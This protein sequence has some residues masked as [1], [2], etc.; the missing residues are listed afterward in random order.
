MPGS[1]LMKR[2]PVAMIRASFCTSPASVSTVRPPSLRPVTR[3]AMNST[4]WSLRK[5]SR[6]R[7]RSWPLRNPLGIQIR[8]GR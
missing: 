4:P 6:G 7:I 3:P 5:R 2:P 8:L 1:F